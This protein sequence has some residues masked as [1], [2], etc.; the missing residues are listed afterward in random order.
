MSKT[1]K[2][3]VTSDDLAFAVECLMR[4]TQDHDGENATSL[5]RVAGWLAGEIAEREERAQ[6]R[7]VTKITGVTMSK[8]RT[9]LRA[10]KR[11]AGA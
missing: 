10:S 7:A 9:V 8:A 3:R 4:D 6:A 5:G 2:P 11:E 1:W